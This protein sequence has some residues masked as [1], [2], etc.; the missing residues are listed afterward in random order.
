[1]IAEDNPYLK[2][3]PYQEISAIDAVNFRPNS[4][5]LDVR[6]K[7]FDNATKSWTL[8]DSGSCLSVI[9]KKDSDIKD[10]YFKL[11]AVNGGQIDTFG[12]EKVVLRIG[13]KTYEIEAI[14]ADIPQKI[15]G[16]DLFT[17]YSLGL[18]WG[19]FG[20][21]YITD[22]KANIKSPLKHVT[23]PINEALRVDS[24]SVIDFDGECTGDLYQPPFIQSLSANTIQFQT[25]CMQ[26][27]EEG[28]KEISAISVE[29][30][31]ETPYCDESLPLKSDQSKIEKK[32]LAALAKTG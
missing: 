6:P 32:N 31:Q 23:L 15:L 16:W 19:H 28:L 12:T 26:Q 3:E 22:K 13:R 1:M 10:P 27:L 24:A 21:L 17:K 8:I 2:M 9:P 29:V 4:Y 18:E 14:K 20:D 11:K 7:V 30:D 25:K 5:G